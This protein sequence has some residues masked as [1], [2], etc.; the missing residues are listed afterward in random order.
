MT[1]THATFGRPAADMHNLPDSEKRFEF[2]GSAFDHIRILQRRENLDVFAVVSIDELWERRPVSHLP[3]SELDK[4][5]DEGEESMAHIRNFRVWTYDFPAAP[6]S[7]SQSTR[8]GVTICWAKDDQ[9]IKDILAM[10]N[11]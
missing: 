6:E 10:V 4:T 3:I 1:K 8:R 7:T 5:Q 11:P 2:W 9:D